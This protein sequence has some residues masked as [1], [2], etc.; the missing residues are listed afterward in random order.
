VSAVS[1]VSNSAYVL[2]GIAITPADTGK[3]LERMVSCNPKS[4]R[5]AGVA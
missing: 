2:E 3:T 5:P 1:G 4:L